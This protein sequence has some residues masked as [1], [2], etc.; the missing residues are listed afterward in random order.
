GLDVPSTWE[1]LAESSLQLQAEGLVEY[2]FAWQGARYEGLSCNWVEYL[3]DAGGQT[4]SDDDMSPSLESPAALRALRFLRSLVVDGVSPP[5][6]TVFEEP[7]ATQEF[8]SGNVAFMRN[9]ALYYNKVVARSEPTMVEN[10]GVAPL[11]T[12]AGQPSPGSSTVGGW[13]LFIAPKTEKLDAARVFIDW[14]T[15]DQA[16]RIIARDSRLPANS[17]VRYDPAV[18]AEN[19]IFSVVADSRPVLRPSGRPDYPEISQAVY[20]N[21]H[22]AVSGTVPPDMALAAAAQMIRDATGGD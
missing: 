13:S 3:A 1:A 20:E 9:W 18:A 6:V 16:Q 22:S 4:L 11:P 19:P 17:A 14:L 7:D 10:I 21:V 12:F 15:D 8:I 5:D 2:G